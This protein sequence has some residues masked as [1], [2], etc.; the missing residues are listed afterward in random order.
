MDNVNK[1]NKKD[2]EDNTKKLEKV[3]A[4]LEKINN[5]ISS[6]KAELENINNEL[7]ASKIKLEYNTYKGDD[8][9]VSEPNLL[10][11]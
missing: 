1:V 5:D 4:E 11:P 10:T 7:D 9:L 3:K 8:L 6:K 2:I